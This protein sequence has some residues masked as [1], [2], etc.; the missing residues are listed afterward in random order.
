MPE[1]N[2]AGVHQIDAKKRKRQ[3]ANRTKTGCGT[4]RRRKKKCDEAK[5]ECMYKTPDDMQHG[6]SALTHAQVTTAIEEALY[7]KVTQAKFRGRR[8]V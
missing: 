4:C 2:R 1:V 7:A 5:P 6:T 8:T 3:F